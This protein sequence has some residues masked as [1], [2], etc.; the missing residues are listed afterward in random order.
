[1]FNIICP[2]TIPCEVMENI[3]QTQYEEVVI[4]KYVDVC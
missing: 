2:A 4:V 1:M 3:E